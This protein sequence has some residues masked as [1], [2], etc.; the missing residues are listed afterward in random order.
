MFAILLIGL[1]LAGPAFAQTADS[2]HAYR[3]EDRPVLHASPVTGH[4]R[5]DGKLDEP[6]WAQAVPADVF[7]QR[8]PNEGQ[9]VS[10]RTEIRVLIGDDAL[11]LGA[12]LYDR[13]AWKI[14]R[15]LVRRD[16][17]FASDY[18]AVLID[19]Y[20]DH[21]TCYRFRVSPAGS[22]DDSF[23]DARGNADFSWDPVWRVHT[24]V[25]SLGWTAEMEI[26]LSQLR[27]N[28][29]SDAV[30][31]IQI[32]RWI[33]RKQE[34][35]EFA[36]TPK[37]ETSDVSRF[38]H[39]TGLGQMA[40]PRHVEL[41]PYSSAK[42]EYQYVPNGNPFR[43]GA[44]HHGSIGAD[45]K[46][47]LTSSLT[48]DAT[49]NP[50]FGQ[51]EVDP[52][53]VNLTTVETFFPER[54]P[55]FV[56]RADLFQ[57]G[58]SRS[59][60]NFNNTIPFHARRIGR[61]PQ[62]TLD[63]NEFRFVDS[64]S[65][66]TIDMAAKLTGKTRG[67]TSVG[68]LD[69][70]TAAERA[71]YVD[72]L[73]VERE[74]EVEPLTNYTVARLRREYA[75]GNTMLGGIATG[76]VRDLGN[77]A[78]GSM[79]R[80]HAYATGVD[81]NHYWA[82]RRWNVDGFL[83]GSHIRGSA[84][85]ID[86]AQRSSVRYY[87][88][89]DAT[90]LHY[91]PTRTSLNG[92]AGE[93]SVNKIG[94]T[95]W[96]GSLTYQDWSPGVEINDL[97]YMNQADSRGISTLVLY[98][99]SKPGKLFRNWDAFAFSNHSFNYGGDLTYQG[100]ETQGEWNFPNY[101]YFQSRVS[102][103]PGS[104]DD[105]LTRGGPMARFPAGGRVN[106]ML[107]SDSRRSWQASLSANYS[108]DDAGGYLKEFTPSLSLH[109]APAMLVKF[110]PTL[111]ELQDRGGYVG[112]TPDPTATATYGSRYVFATLLQRTVSLDTR[113]NWTFSPKLSLQIYVQPLVVTALYHDLKEL[114]AP[115]TFEFLVYGKNA[116]TIGRDS[117]GAYVIDPDASG[118][119]AAYTMADPNFN[120]RSLLGNAVLRWE[121]R[122]GS[123]IF[124]VWQQN[125][126][127]TQPFG[128]FDFS[129]DFRGLLENGP[130]NIV[131]LKATYWLGI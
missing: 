107:M 83:L 48:L 129:R 19:S 99:Q 18:L 22:Y 128:D 130:E 127:E 78:L 42:A 10:E 20:H 9:P 30:W 87:Q 70:V 12:K 103:Y 76:V 2:T 37:N 84:D 100:Y 120:Y 57:F 91:D 85:A 39:L 93:F 40:A 74:E 50:D 94:G 64:P 21:L 51:V 44:D 54:R 67:G 16:E 36:F 72:S 43:D 118:P 17:D 86:R 35:A 66:T 59:F 124:L 119:A 69:A 98:K 28:S 38:G 79:L 47:G 123:A 111:R 33:D 60:N 95:H 116:G 89:P 121:Y 68:F 101:W 77:P 24:N 82:A 97:G 25:D 92:A 53:V 15:R 45:L 63:E 105:R 81:F 4:I 131:A 102:W 13:E 114:E 104:F 80:S 6:D 34:L 3:H 61:A 122:P 126:S 27:Y 11:Y 52:A 112:V 113:V 7:T 125:R 110:T 55:F 56:E 90:H 65:L 14:R 88:R 32:R 58:Q 75:Q 31:G 29:A 71:H 5:I 108:W 41:L 23:L 1:L 62:R 109:P 49:V 115:R 117:T 46:Y 73:G 26:P 8:D 106:A 96:E